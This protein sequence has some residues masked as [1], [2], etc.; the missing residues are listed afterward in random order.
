MGKFRDF[1]RK[2]RKGITAAVLIAIGVPVGVAVNVGE[3]VDEYT[4]NPPAI[5]ATA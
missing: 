5:T 4:V 3:A 1:W 2:H